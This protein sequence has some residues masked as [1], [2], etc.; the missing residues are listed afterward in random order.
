MTT[1]PLFYLGNKD[2]EKI[3]QIVMSTKA[4]NLAKQVVGATINLA[5]IAKKK[6][7][8]RALKLKPGKECFNCKKKGH[9]IKDYHSLILNKR[10][11]KK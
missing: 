9:Y 5:I 4:A 8:E 2:F 1:A 11:P 7:L 6:Q 3:Q 10:K